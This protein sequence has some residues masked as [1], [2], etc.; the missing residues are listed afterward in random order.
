MVDVC[1]KDRRIGVE[2]EARVHL[3]YCFGL[4]YSTFGRSGLPI[5]ECEKMARGSY[6]I[7]SE[8]RL[9]ERICEGNRNHRR[10]DRADE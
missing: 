7:R 2:L 8:T 9:I 3:G 10:I 4:E 1:G 5:H 6:I